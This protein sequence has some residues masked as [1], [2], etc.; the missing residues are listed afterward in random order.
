MDQ[1]FV[2]ALG[3]FL[4]TVFDLPVAAIALLAGAFASSRQSAAIAFVAALTIILA[5]KAPQIYEMAEILGI[6]DPSLVGLGFRYGFVVLVVMSLV[7]AV[8]RAVSPRL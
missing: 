3:V 4:A 8:K 5:I 2:E 1:G 7:Y 6:P